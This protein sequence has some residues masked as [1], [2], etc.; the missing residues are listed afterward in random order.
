MRNSL[1]ISNS[2]R[3]KTVCKIFIF[4]LLLSIALA[5]TAKVLSIKESDGISQWEVFYDIEKNS[6]D[7]LV[8]GSSH[9]Y[10]N[11]NP[12]AMYEENGVAAFNLCASMQPMWNSYYFIKEALKYQSPKLIVLEGYGACYNDDY[13]L[14]GSKDAMTSRIIK[15]NYGMK[16]SFLKLE[17]IVDSVPKS[18]LGDYLIEFMQ[19]HNR[20]ESLEMSDFYESSRYPEGKSWRGQADHFDTNPQSVTLS[21]ETDCVSMTSKTEEYFKKIVELANENDIALCVLLTPY[22]GIHS[23]EEKVFNYL[24]DLCTEYD[25][26]FVNYNSLDY[27]QEIGLDFDTDYVDEVHMNYRGNEK[28]SKYLSKYLSDNYELAD[29]RG[30]G[31]YEAWE[32][33][34]CIR[35]HKI[36]ANELVR[37]SS[38]ANYRE[39]LDNLDVSDSYVYF[40][41]KTI[42]GKAVYAAACDGSGE[43]FSSDDSEIPFYRYEGSWDCIWLDKDLKIKLNDS[44]YEYCDN[45]YNVL[46]YDST[47]GYVVDSFGIEFSNGDV[48]D[49]L[50]RN[51]G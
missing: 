6:L 32:N 14:Y 29:R 5:V 23:S 38:L 42:D 3:I 17:S 45:G 41:N 21:G 1:F 4:I 27:Y 20:Y 19:S 51:G 26:D 39:Y 34:L 50:I 37:T 49:N 7:V 18:E 40:Y 8:V 15:N 16:W 30:D 48:S 22:P 12:V 44:V 35:A 31:S 47:T 25:V 46:I 11:I 2:K 36:A 24:S 9:A 28:F 10:V 33:E 43:F 13:T